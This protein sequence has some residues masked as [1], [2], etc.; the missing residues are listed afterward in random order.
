[1]MTT[2]I[3]IS[4]SVFA[5]LLTSILAARAWAQ[6]GAERQEPVRHIDS[7]AVP[8]RW[9]TNTPE[10]K[11]GASRNPLANGRRTL[12]LRVKVDY[13]NPV[14]NNP[15]GWPAMYLNHRA[16]EKGWEKFERFEFLVMAR[17]SQWTPKGVYAVFQVMCPDKENGIA[18]IIRIPKPDAWMRVSIPI[19]SITN[20]SRLGSLL[21]YTAE[22]QYEDGQIVEFFLGDFRLAGKPGQGPA[23]V[24]GAAPRVTPLIPTKD[25]GAEVGFNPSA[26]RKAIA[27]DFGTAESPVREGFVRMTDKSAF[28]AGT[29]AGWLKTDGLTAVDRG[30][31]AKVGG[32]PVFYSNDLRRDSVQSRQAATLRVKAPA[33]KYRVWILAG[34]GGGSEAQVWDV[35]VAGGASSAKATFY[36]PETPRLMRLD[37]VESKEGV[38]DLNISTRSVWALNG[39]IIAKEDEWAALEKTAIAALEREVTMLPDDVLEK[40]TYLPHKDDTPQPKYTAAEKTR[41]FVLYGKPWVTPVW[42]NTVPKREEFNPTLRAFAC[43]DEYEPMTFTVMP[44]RNLS[45]AI[46]T[47][48]D[49]RNEKGDTIAAGNIEVRY[50][51]YEY[52]RVRYNRHEKYRLVPNLLPLFQEPRSLKANENLRTWLTVHA[53]PGTPEGVYRGAATLTIGEE[54]VAEV[55]IEFRVLPITLRKDPSLTYGTYYRHASRWISKAPDDFSRRWWTSKLHNDLKSMAEHGIESYIAYVSASRGKGGRWVVRLDELKRQLDL[56]GRYGFAVRKPWVGNFQYSLNKL[57]RKYMGKSIPGHLFGVEMPPQAFFDEVTKMVQAMEAERKR[58]GLPE[59][60]YY[61]FDEP[62]P[63]TEESIRFM[64]PLLQ[65]VK[66]VPGV[67]TYVTAYPT[68][69]PYAPMKPY[70]DVWCTQSFVA[71]FEQVQRER[72]ERGV[73]YWCYPNFVMAGT[74]GHTQIAA[75]RMVYGFGLWRSG[76]Q[77]LVP[78]TFQAFYGDPENCLDAHQAEFGI[79]ADDD[80]N[81]VPTML[82]EGRR[83]GYDDYRYLATLKYWIAQARKLGHKKEAQEGSRRSRGR[84]QTPLGCS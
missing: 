2:R 76:Y 50:V 4:L 71:P 33:G 69:A 21:F 64:T 1:M 40:W 43:P 45:N 23:S 83:E 74:Q 66:K 78:W 24:P 84:P 56:A 63:R 22:K 30:A 38:L 15:I 75:A 70:V 68:L 6:G 28:G 41:G 81:V 82:Y 29:Q 17:S 31:P 20:L 11:I 3:I 36:G 37:A 47:V 80:G 13:E 8:S 5:L 19:A 32:F 26:L 52:V 67:R 44:L 79:H 27:L 77:V 72:K 62:N 54:Q 39:I 55:P 53:P 60:I 25:A 58:C 7:F 16:D 35:R 59:I 12:R 18:A 48:T 57:Y 46:V 10:L 34:T 61:P 49:L 14:G 73:E 42:P 65:A 9:R 51:R